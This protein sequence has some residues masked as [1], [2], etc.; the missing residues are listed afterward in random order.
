[1]RDFFLYSLCAA[2]LGA[3]ASSAA[4][5]D[6]RDLQWRHRVIVVFAG[7]G[8]ADPQRSD[9]TRAMIE[10]DGR[11]IAERDIAWFIVGPDSVQSNVK[12]AIERA[13]LE[14]LH[15]GE[16]FEAVLLGK[17]GSVKARQRE[18]LDLAALFG[19]IDTMPMRQQEMKDHR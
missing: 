8:A 4:A 3:G 1:M 17:D 7:D 19:Q 11:G 14:R 6:L 12:E 16:G 13:S 10:N 15:T 18:R 5:A 9:K 2:V